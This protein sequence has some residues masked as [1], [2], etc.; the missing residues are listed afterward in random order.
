MNRFVKDVL[1][2]RFWKGRTTV[3]ESPL[4]RRFRAEF[5]AG[6]LEDDA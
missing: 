4:G 5:E 3:T 6:A 1:C 2:P